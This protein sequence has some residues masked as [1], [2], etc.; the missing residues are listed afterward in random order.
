MGVMEAVIS[1][2][3]NTV[4]TSHMRLLSTSSAARATKTVD[5]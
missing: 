3:S 2:L 5:F 1:E 4:L